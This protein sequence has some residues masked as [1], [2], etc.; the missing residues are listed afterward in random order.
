METQWVQKEG[1]LGFLSPHGHMTSDS[2]NQT[3]KSYTVFSLGFTHSLEQ[4]SRAP[5]KVYAIFGMINTQ[6]QP[7]GEHRGRQGCPPQVPRSC[8]ARGGI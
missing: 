2:E 6:S 7:Q 5:T 1:E 4:V 8:L 3:L